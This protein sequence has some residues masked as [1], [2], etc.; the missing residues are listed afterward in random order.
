MKDHDSYGLPH[1]DSVTLSPLRHT[2]F[3][4]EPWND[5]QSE[6]GNGERGLCLLW[7]EEC[8]DGVGVWGEVGVAGF[9]CVH[10]VHVGVSHVDC[11]VG[12]EAG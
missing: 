9:F 8:G 2:R 1:P 7:R 11:A 5:T 6:G 3:L 12:W 10:S 4:A